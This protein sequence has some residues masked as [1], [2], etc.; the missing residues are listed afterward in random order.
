MSVDCRRCVSY[1]VECFVAAEDEH[2]PCEYY[3]PICPVC[4]EA[5]TED[6]T[7][8]QICDHPTCGSEECIHEYSDHKDPHPT[9]VCRDCVEAEQTRREE[10]K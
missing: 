10:E 9:R 4:G 3:R 6:P 1:D 2:S 7:F 8:C 5:P